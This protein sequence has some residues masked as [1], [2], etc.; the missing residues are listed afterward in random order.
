[1]PAKPLILKPYIREAFPCGLRLHSC[2]KEANTFVIHVRPTDSRT[3]R[4]ML[5]SSYLSQS[6]LGGSEI[7]ANSLTYLIS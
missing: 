2:Q 5:T 7:I 4:Q 6:R 3:E 1:M